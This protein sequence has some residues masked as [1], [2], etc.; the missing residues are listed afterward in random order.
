M[1]WLSPSLSA[2][3]SS[4]SFLGGCS[5]STNIVPEL[6]T[7][8]RMEGVPWGDH[9]LYKGPSRSPRFACI[10]V[11]ISS[12][13]PDTASR[14]AIIFALTI[15]YDSGALLRGKTPAVAQGA[16]RGGALFG[17]ISF[18][19]AHP[20]GSPVSHN[21]FISRHPWRASPVKTEFSLCIFLLSALWLLEL[22]R[23]NPG[24]STFSS[25]FLP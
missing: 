2:N 24:E 18:L 3:T 13:C 19:G 16:A 4:H 22:H 9:V 7:G 8:T 15:R 1:S 5:G 21:V 10:V 6:P 23:R 25:V 17:P 11:S 12:P 20:F 14:G